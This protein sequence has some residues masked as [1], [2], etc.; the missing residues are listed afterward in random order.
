[1]LT[2]YAPEH[3]KDIEFNKNKLDFCKYIND[4]IVKFPNLS[5]LDK[6]QEPELF[7]VEDKINLKGVLNTF[8]NILK[9]KMYKYFKENEK[10]TAF[11]KIKKY[12]LTKIYEKIY[13][14]D[15]DNDDLLFFYKAISLSW[16]EPKHLKIPYEVNVDNF[17]PITNSFFKQVDYEKSPSCK[18]EVI[19]KI[20][21]TI[22]WA[23]KLSN[24]GNFST[25]DIAPI[26]EYALIKARPSRLSSNLKYLEFFKANG[27]ELKDMYF[28]FLKSNMNSIKEINYSKF[29]GITE[30]EFKKKCFEANKQYI[31]S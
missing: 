16:I 5:K 7:E 10:D 11:N 30:E 20:F 15:Y 13:P 28:D 17:I 18:M 21:N 3:D 22:N 4:F 19:A 2:I 29:E 14:Q 27:S 24:A 26:F 12:I 8:M 23:L 6:G 1:M 31:E 9:D 25:D